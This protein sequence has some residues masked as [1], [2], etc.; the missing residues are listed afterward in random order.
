MMKNRRSFGISRRPFL[1]GLGASAGVATLLH[2]LIAQAEGALPKRFLWIHYPCGTVAGFGAEGA[3]SAWT[4]FPTG[5]GTTY[6]PSSL[7]KLFDPVKGSI[8]PFDGIDLGDPNQTT[9][10][11]KHAQGM[12]WMGTGWMAVNMNTSQVDP[13]QANNHY[14]TVRQGTK[15]IDQQLLDVVPDLTAPLVAGGTGPIYRSIQLVGTPTSMSNQGFTCLR[16]L[17]YAGKDQPLFGE[18]RSQTAF[19]NI[20]SSAMAPGVD[21]VVY[22]RQQAQKK[23]V[24]DL[25]MDDIV[26]LQ[27]IVPV[28][29]RPKFDA[30]LSSIR[31]LE[32]RVSTPPPPAGQI[33]KPV[34]LDEPTTG[35]DGANAN[36]ARHE[37]LI[38]NQLEIIRTAFASDLTRVATISYAD[39]N[40]VLRP[41][42]FVP[43]PT[44]SQTGDGHSVSHAGKSADAINAKGQVVA[45]YTRLT[46]E[47]LT[48]MSKTVEGTSNL[49]D[50]TLGMYFSE[51]RDGDSHERRRNPCM[52]FGGKF[53]NLKTGQYLVLN[54]ARYANDIWASVLTAWDVP[55]TV[56]GDPM[57]GKGVLPG[58]FG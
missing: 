39:G 29:Q 41:K 52:L 14:I 2:P 9:Q 1:A 57:Y 19:N 49:L 53:L 42:S 46:A 15:S 45:M 13:D 4:W 11:D 33:I 32:A 36:E 28:A 58:L 55:T 50:N 12:M 16:V 47:L 43:N 21:P 17:S 23:S 20:F 30:Q 5:S 22:A 24:L 6:T 26:R 34:L 8:L 48:N 7:T 51:C 31:A 27:A 44:F 18:G 54:P 25:V 10:G 56:Y 40:N 35:H 38:R 3:G 37:T